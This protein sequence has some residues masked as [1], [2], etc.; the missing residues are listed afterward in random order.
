MRLTDGARAVWARTR[1]LT[2]PSWLGPFG[3]EPWIVLGP[4]I[5]VQ[6][7][8]L[9]VFMVTVRH[10]SWLYYQG[11]DQTFYWTTGWSFAHWRLPTAEVGWGWS[12]LLTPLA[13]ITGN[14]VLSG[15]PGIILVD[16]L[17][18]LPVALLGMYGIGARKAEQFG[19]AF[20]EEIQSYLGR[21]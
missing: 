9:I 3:R 2:P 17:V 5:L 13:G 10:N 16:T 15:L 14:N 1:S 11:G 12:Y 21:G 8:A 6:W 18:L 4:L 19:P 20:I 7:L